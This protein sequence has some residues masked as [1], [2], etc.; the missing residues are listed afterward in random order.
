M[1]EYRVGDW[2][3]VKFPADETGKARK[4]S[5]P[6]HGPYRVVDIRQPDVTVVKVY[7]PQ[8]GRIQIHQTRVTPCPPAFP[9]GYFWYGDKRPRPGRPPKWV[10]ELLQGGTREANVDEND[11]ATPA[12]GKDHSSDHDQPE[13][14][15]SAD[16]SLE[17]EC[18]PEQDPTTYTPPQEPT[19][20]RAPDVT[21]RYGLRSRVVPPDRLYWVQAR[22][23]L[24]LEGR[25]V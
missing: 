16:E 19:S 5:R 3:L 20:V 7:R 4:L 2:V 22:G 13:E 10:D 24:S 9:A 21:S 8:D 18:M 25:V 1:K 12:E 14:H 17:A 11:K 23:E 6:W 15:L